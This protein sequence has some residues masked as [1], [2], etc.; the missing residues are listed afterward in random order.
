[1]SRFAPRVPGHRTC[2][3]C[4]TPKPLKEFS[5]VNHRVCQDCVDARLPSLSKAQRNRARN[6]AYVELARAHKEEY[7]RLYAKELLLMRNEN[8]IAEI[9]AGLR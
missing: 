4:E 9:M 8:A 6:R 1:V 5:E 7:D 2:R 3:R